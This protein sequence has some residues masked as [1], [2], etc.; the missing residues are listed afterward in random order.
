MKQIIL[1]LLLV[2]LFAAPSIVYAQDIQETKQE[3]KAR[4]K[5]EKEEAKRLEK[6]EKERKKAEEKA[7]KEEEKKKNEGKPKWSGVPEEMS[8]IPEVD[9]YILKVDS[10]YTFVNAYVD[11]INSYQR[12]VVPLTDPDGQIVKASDGTPYLKTTIVDRNGDGVSI[13]QSILMLPEMSTALMGLSV[14]ALD[15]VAKGLSATTAFISNPMAAFTYGKYLKEGPKVLKYLGEESAR[16]GRLAKSQYDILL[17]LRK[18]QVTEDLGLDINTD[19]AIINTP[20]DYEEATGSE[21]ILKELG[22][23]I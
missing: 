21:D 5:R 19:E 8:G 20:K 23:E 12:V 18:S 15:I 4:E 14:E 22:I 17:V 10:I 13:T 1:A 3:Q 9:D 16:L 2:S 6:E 7:R 11:S